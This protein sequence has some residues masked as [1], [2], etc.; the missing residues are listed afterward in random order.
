MRSERA[1]CAFCGKINEG[2]LLEETGGLFECD[3]CGRKN[4]AA[5]Y[6]VEQTFSRIESR[7]RAAV[8]PVRKAGDRHAS[9][10]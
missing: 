10:E 3:R 2:L 5:E 4:T 8:L 6:L 1:V 9:S 7:S